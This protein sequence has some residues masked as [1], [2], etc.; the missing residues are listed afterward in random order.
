MNKQIF[1]TYKFKSSR[2]EEFDYDIQE[3]TFEKAKENKEV[4]SMFDSQLLRSV[5]R[6]NGKEFNRDKLSRLKN[7]LK[8]LKK[9]ENSKDNAKK[10]TAL[11]KQINEMLFVPEIISIVVENKKHYQYLFKNKLNINGK[12]YRRLS[13]SAGQ[14]RASTVIFC[15]TEIADELDKIFD[16]GRDTKKKLVPSKFNA[17]KGLITSSTSVVSTPNFCLVPDCK[18]KRDVKVNFVT[19]TGLNEDDYIEVRTIKETFNLFDGQGLISV[20]LARKWADELGLDYVPSQWCIRHNYIK[21]MVNVFDFKAFCEEK[22]E[23][24]YII[25][26]SY[27]DENGNKKKV[28]L[29]TV[30][31]IISESQFKLWDSFSGIEEY[32]QNCE[33]NGLYWGVSLVSPKKDKDILKMNYQFLQTVKLDNASDVEKIC[34]KFVDWI[35]G[36]TSKDIHYTILFLLGTEMDEEEIE[37]FLEQS[38][39]YWVKALMVDHELINDKWIKKKIYDLIKNKIKNGCLGQI[40]LDGNFQVLVSDPFAQMQH[41]CGQTVTGLLGEKEYYSHYWNER[42]VEVV[43]SM[44]APLTYRSEHVLLNLKQGK[45]LNKWYEHNKTGIIVNVHGHET[46][47]WA[48]SDFDMDIIATCSDTTLIKGVYKDELPIAYEPPKATPDKLTDRRLYNADL[49]SFGSEIGQ[50]TNKSTS[51]Y[52]LLPLF[53]ED[54]KEYEITMRRIKMCTKLQSAQIDKAK[55]GRQVKSIPK[56]WMKYN[57]VLEEDSPEQKQEKE[58]LNRTLLNKHPYFFTYLYKGTKKK[59]KQFYNNQDV[60]CRQKFGISLNEL[61]KL[62]RKTPD[63]I[64]FLSD[65]HKYSPVIDSDCTMN[66]ICKYI[67]SIDFGIRGIIKQETSNDFHKRLMRNEDFVIDDSIYNKIKNAHKDFKET[68]LSLAATTSDEKSVKSDFDDILIS[69]INTTYSKLEESLNKI[70]SNTYEIVDYLIHMFYV[71]KTDSNKEVLWKIYGEYIYENVKRKFGK[72][73]VPV[74]SENGDIEYLGKKYTL[75]EVV[76]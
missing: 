31:L 43:D 44:R 34:S 54:S 13:C 32:N 37:I 9:Q 25:E 49:H 65:F 51:G 3:L 41:V 8:F 47:N 42:G 6:L 23:K 71:D 22:N 24:N 4:I 45:E 40:I 19:E 70:S 60:T 46:I 15:D 5:R 55:I 10:I 1:Y 56:I 18:M 33:K 68:S 53:D 48:G 69:N 52:A 21:G 11:S 63:Q 73:I 30:D 62:D 72:V 16:N 39:N 66:K 28:D 76:L 7:K 61:R 57:R 59:Y 36:V 75:K 20:E 29:N 64:T 26:T 38:E 27:L 14:A 74:P 12:I 35:S 50:I 17:Y 2:L 67:E 58:L